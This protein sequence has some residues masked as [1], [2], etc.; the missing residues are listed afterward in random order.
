MRWREQKPRPWG[1]CL[2]LSTVFIQA[3]QVRVYRWNHQV[4]MLLT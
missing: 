4:Y 3:H 1:G 2:D